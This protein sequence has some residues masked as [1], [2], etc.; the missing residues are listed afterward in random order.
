MRVRTMAVCFMLVGLLGSTA[1]AQLRVDARE[2]A[3]RI[4]DQMPPRYPLEA[5]QARIQG[6]VVLDAVIDDAG[7]VTDLSVMTGHPLLAPAAAR[8]V[9]QWRYDPYTVDG[10]PVAVATTVNVTFTL[11]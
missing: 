6:T 10:Q 11:N 2:M 7:L 3:E 8:A 9:G 1:M 5:R 4:I